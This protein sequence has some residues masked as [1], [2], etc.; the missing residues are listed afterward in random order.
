MAWIEL[1]QE[2][3][4]HPKIIRLANILQIE[5]VEATGALINLWL[6][7]VQYAKN[8]DL[9]K[10]TDQEIGQACN[11]PER[12]FD[13]LVTK[14]IESGWIDQKNSKKVIHDWKIYGLKYL[15][16]VN[17]RVRKHREKKKLEEEINSYGNVTVIATIPNLT[18]QNPTLP[19]ISRHIVETWNAFALE[20]GLTTVAKL[21]DK[22]KGS[23][24]SRIRE[25]EFNLVKIF[26]EIKASPFLLGE[27]GWRVDFDFVFCSA[28]NYLKIIE[29]KYRKTNGKNIGGNNAGYKNTKAGGATTDED[30]RK[31]FLGTPVRE[32]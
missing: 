24:N 5:S 26:D 4:L 8:G 20:H 17:D 9:T 7:S 19:E 30:V 11:L 32:G 29:Q 18:V 12:N 27:K 21:T 23:I 2:L 6:W 31:T 22:R 14:L 10:F 16:S 15:N 13:G 1:H 25:K 28:N 3:R